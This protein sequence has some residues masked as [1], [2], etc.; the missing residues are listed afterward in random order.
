VTGTERH[1]EGRLI[2]GRY[3]L[4]RRIGGGAMGVVWLAKDELLDRTVAVKQL[5]LTP[6]LSAQE[7]DHA[8]KR[9]SR[10]ARIAARLQH[11]HAITV[12][13]VADDDGLPVLIMEYLPSRSLAEVLAAHGA[14]P[15]AE[16]ARI[17]AHAASALAAAHTAGIVHRDVKPGN[18]LL[19]EDGVAKI[20]DFGISR[21]V[22][23]GT[24]TG[25]GRFAGTPAFLSPE[26]ARGEEP[27]AASDVYSLGAT[28]YII[29]EGRFPYGETENQMAM[30][31][32]A[33]AGRVR[34]PVLAGPLTDV[35]DRMMRLAPR[36]R[37]T[38]AEVATELEKLSHPPHRKRSRVPVY[39]GIAAVVL[40]AAVVTTVLLLTGHSAE[41]TAAP[42]VSTPPQ[43]TS[44]PA[45]APSPSPAGTTTAG[46]SATSASASTSVSTSTSTA[47]T[48]SLTQAVSDYYAIMP[49]N[50]D[51]GWT[52]LGP[53]LQAQGKTRY[54]SWWSGVSNLVVASA[55]RLAGEN[56]VE[57]TI[58]YSINGE[59]VHEVHRLGMITRDGQV[60]INT[61]DD[62]TSTR[63]G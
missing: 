18:I 31:Y 22:D 41:H 16:V 59:R 49:G 56:T 17:G 58:E 5:L 40:A 14:L 12:F 48:V 34:P 2:A 26:A 7:A 33:A 27:S 53:V 19:G 9:A 39:A 21:A 60:L 46:I 52:K 32:A 44:G 28:L 29:V 4:E 8:R 13:D 23:D 51:V 54:R 45:A 3:R 37:P 6:G 24:L 55:P 20:T 63:I 30:L 47:A 50:P 11:R 62:V 43:A 61:D 15:P 25:S 36:E 10:E 35:L 42:G 57:V 38:M 1:D